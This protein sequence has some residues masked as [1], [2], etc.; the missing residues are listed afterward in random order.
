MKVLLLGKNG[1]LG[2]E[3]VRAFANDQLLAF[4]RPDINF[5][6]TQTLKVLIDE[7]QPDVVINAVA[8]TD[9]DGCETETDLAMQVNATAVGEL[10]KM[11]K[12]VGAIVVH[13]S[14]DYVFDGTNRD[15]YDETATPNPI[16]L[17]GRTKALGEELLQQATDAH[18]LIRTSYLFGINGKNFVRTIVEK[19][20]AG[21]PLAIV[22]DQFSKPSFARDVAQTTRS[23]VI[24]SKEFGTYHMTNE[25]VTSMYD[26]GKEILR[27]TGLKTDLTTS[28]W[29]QQR[30]PAKRPQY[31]ALLNTKLLPLRS[32]QEAVTDCLAEAEYR[33]TVA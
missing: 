8:Y 11:A 13:Y 24:S 4:D 10:A 26:F 5:Q 23:L 33:P 7:H 3:L 18:Y 2:S 12:A 9:V 21:E 20:Q 17:Y 27:I 15:G 22:N 29:K 32:W 31:S 25:P 30:R 28:S 16:S 19:A 14:T 1:M 6:Q